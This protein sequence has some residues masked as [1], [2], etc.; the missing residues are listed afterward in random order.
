M[1]DAMELGENVRVETCTGAAIVPLLPA[2]QRLRT[3][4]FRAWPYLYDG[5]PE[6]ESGY[7]RALADSPAAAI[8]VAFGDGVPVGAS[9]CL[10]LADETANIRAPFDARGLDPARV[11]YFGESVL[12]PAWRGGGIGVAFFERREAH[13][14]QVSACDYAAFCSV[15]RPADHPMRPP[16]AV[17]LDAFWRNRGYT[18][19]PDLACTMSWKCVGQNAASPHTLRFW[20]KPL[21]GAKLP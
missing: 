12:L 14:L 18:S 3:T 8:V 4:V 5:D 19:Y 1:Q 7:L 6:Q 15:E 2:L 16:G 10:P 9:T 21:H 20:L 13:A 11:F 17:P